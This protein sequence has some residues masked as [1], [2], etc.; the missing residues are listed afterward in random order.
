MLEKAEQ[1]LAAPVASAAHEALGRAYEA[2]CN[3]VDAKVGRS[4][5]NCAPI[6]ENRMGG[7]YAFG[8]G[9]LLGDDERDQSHIVDWTKFFYG[10]SR[11]EAMAKLAQWCS[12]HAVRVDTIPAPPSQYLAEDG[13]PMTLPRIDHSL[14][15]EKTDGGDQ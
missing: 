7:N 2:V 11:G 5:V 9:V 10:A 3:W 6:T 14:D 15:V 13:L 4:F 1:M 12:E 8:A